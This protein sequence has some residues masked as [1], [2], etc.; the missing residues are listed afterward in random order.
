M[1]EATGSSGKRQ[2]QLDGKDTASKKGV[3]EVDFL[4]QGI[5]EAEHLNFSHY[6]GRQNGSVVGEKNETV[7]NLG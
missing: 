7:T 1:R 5:I 3:S 6:L 2:G 4:H